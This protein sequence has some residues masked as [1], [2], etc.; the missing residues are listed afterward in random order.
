MLVDMA[1]IEPSL[2][3]AIHKPLTVE[4]DKYYLPLL[5]LVISDGLII[6]L[7]SLLAY[8]CRFY[9]KL[10][11]W[12]P[13]P[14]PP[15][16]P[17]FFDYL[18]LAL[19]MALMAVFIFER[20]GFYQR[21]I[22]LDR[23]VGALPLLIALMVT[24]VFVM[25][26][27]FNYRE[28]TYSR[29]TMAIAFP[30]TCIAVVSARHALK[31][32]QFYMIRNGIGFQKTVLVGPPSR[33]L[34]FLKKLHAY[35]G[36][37]YQIMGFVSTENSTRAEFPN[38]LPCL[39]VDND[40]SAI[41]RGGKVDHVIIAMPPADHLRILS[42]IQECRRHDIP[43]R[44]VPDL[45]DLLCQ[46]LSVEEFEILPSILFGET[47]L[48][49]FSRIL[50]RLVDVVVASAALI[51]ASPVMLAIAL[52]IRYDSKGSVFYVQ[53]RV[54]SDGSKFRILKFRSMVENAERDC[55]P[56][57]AT[58][59]DPR[60]THI[61]QFIRRYN[62]DELPQFINVLRGEMSLVGP[63]PERPF[64]V[65]KFKE[66]IPLYMR[67]HMV[68]S[69]ITGWAQVHGLRGDTSV[70]QRT[71]YDLYYLQ[72]WSFLLDVKILW[73]TLTSFKNAY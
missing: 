37:E 9:T 60:T 18:K 34:D 1:K 58:A 13:P 44:I 19:M 32:L 68:K 64:F 6:T 35:H 61:G 55:G 59:N 27:L 14:F 54:G 45:Y 3:P 57:W 66:E 39:G 38:L 42:L 7:S 53:E 69:G 70:A 28:M 36:S 5:I 48:H 26:L 73:K 46:N 29:F 20:F 8:F 65:D 67:R 71:E 23:E 21:R 25:A 49:G 63:R 41:L 33:C 11:E 72:H 16:V 12:F 40:L 56:V 43:Y 52:L 4:K 51:L 17:D 10:Y 50:K 62:L 30:I 31:I 22:G 15:Y 47:S 24:F 2:S